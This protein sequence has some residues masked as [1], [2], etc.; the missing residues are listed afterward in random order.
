LCLLAVGGCAPIAWLGQALI[1]EPQSTI[2][3]EF[4][5]LEGHSVAVV[6]Y[7]DR[8]VLYE[9][10]RAVTDLSELI[11]GQLAQ[12]VKNCRVLDGRGIIHFQDATLDWD[13]MEKTELGKKF[14]ADY[15]LYV[16]LSTF[17]MH[18]GGSDY[19]CRGEIIADVS[20]HKT[21]MPERQSR[22]FAVHSFRVVHPPEAQPADSD[23]VVRAVQ[24]FAETEFATR[25]VKK[26]YKHQVPK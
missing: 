8:E 21:A 15:V 7:A 14:G 3:P 1:P 11:G 13:A 5:D 24:A 23:A 2:E 19:L 17:T 22:V 6:I 18:E 9:Y 10:P 16:A 12:N 25:L 26:F 20:I 4:A